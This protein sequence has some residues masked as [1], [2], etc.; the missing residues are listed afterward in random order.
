[1]SIS[2][3]HGTIKRRSGTRPTGLREDISI[4]HGTIKR[5]SERD[6]RH[7]DVISIP[8]GTIK[9][10][11]PRILMPRRKQFQYL[12]VQL[13]VQQRHGQQQQR[14]PISIPHGTIKRNRRTIRRAG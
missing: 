10:L 11:S 13:K 6:F 4:P 3:P 8:H 12:M 1:M 5:R 9:S 2:I 14:Y 7:H